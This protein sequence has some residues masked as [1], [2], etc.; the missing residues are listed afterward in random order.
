V[1]WSGVFPLGAP[2]PAR[3]EWVEAALGTTRYSVH[4]IV[5]GIANITARKNDLRHGELE[6]HP[7]IPPA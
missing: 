6:R 1:P 4:T 2:S 3:A 5:T 7:S